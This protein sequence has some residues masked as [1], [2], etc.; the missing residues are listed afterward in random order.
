[1]GVVEQQLHRAPRSC[2]AATKGVCCCVCCCWWCLES[3]AA[4]G[5]GAGASYC[6]ILL[7]PL[8]SCRQ[9]APSSPPPSASGPTNRCV[10]LLLLHA[11]AAAACTRETHTD[12]A[13]YG[14][15]AHACLRALAK[16]VHGSCCSSCTPSA[17]SAPA[18]HRA[19]VPR[20]AAPSAAAAPL[21]CCCL[22][23]PRAIM[24]RTCAWHV[25]GAAQARPPV[26][27]RVRV[28][29]PVTWRRAKRTACA[30]LELE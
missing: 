27:V 23:K 8:P 19:A 6:F 2:R 11:G 3:A 4:G 26:R 7:L 12:A 20:T 14:C 25:R 15:C 1:V 16:P 5:A 22:L 29:G 18:R 10:M 30:E 9:E 24:P 28:R 13:R 17:P 21:S